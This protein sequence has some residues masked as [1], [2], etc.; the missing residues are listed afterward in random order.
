MAVN[1]LLKLLD[2][3]FLNSNFFLSA[4]FLLIENQ[5][6]KKKK[7]QLIKIENKNQTNYET[8]M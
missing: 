1:A 4:Y 5:I 3:M 7:K 2:L 6:Y 8:H